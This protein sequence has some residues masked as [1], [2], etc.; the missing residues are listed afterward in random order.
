[1]RNVYLIDQFEAVQNE[2]HFILNEKKQLSQ[3]QSTGQVIVDSDNE[4][5]LYIIEEND[6]YS[7]ISF[8][9]VV[10]PQLLQMLM[11]G[12][13]PYLKVE[14]GTMPLA[15]FVDELKGLLYNIEGNSNYGDHF[16]EAVEKAFA[17]FF[18]E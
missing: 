16:V 4:A 6:A 14:D 2:I 8:S 9:H 17:D 10:W 1:M 18:R 3:L 5:F 15:Q 7:Y 11:S 13:Q 12:Q